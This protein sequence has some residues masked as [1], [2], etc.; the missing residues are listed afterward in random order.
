MLTA[1]DSSAHDQGTR[2]AGALDGLRVIDAATLAA[3]P[4]VA[5]TMAEFG[6]EVIKVEQPG[7]GDPLR[8][9]GT[10][11]NG[12]ALMWKSVGRN[13]KTVTLDLRQREG[14][15]LLRGLVAV[16]DV[17]IVNTRPG[18]LRRWGLTY[19]DLCPANEGLVML[20]VTGFGAGG[21]DS[22]RPGFGTLGEAMSGFAHLTGQKDGPPTLPPFPLADGVA[23]LT[24]T[25]AVMMVLYHRALNGGRGQ[26]IDVNLIEPL[27]R[28]L[29]HAVLTYDQL[30]TVL[31]R[32]GNRWEVSVPRNVYRTADDRWI[33]MSGS[34]PNIAVRVFRAIG[35]PDLIDHPDYRDAQRR[36]QNGVAIDELVAGWV[37]TKTLAEAIDVFERHEVAAAPVYDAQQLLGDRH[38]QARNAYVEVPDPD[39]GSM[40]VQAPV[41]R[42]SLT[43]GRVQRLGAA[44]GA[45]NRAVYQGL[46]GLTDAHL[47]EL[48]TAGVI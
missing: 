9:W 22:D 3:A 32:D 34:T 23:A 39:L 42:L 16:S 40:T 13:K 6:A 38:L 44:I 30:R 20:H 11:K 26:L 35:Q 18:T 46:L 27:A 4:M 41:A 37:A 1:A 17:L 21:P 12:V 43:P 14:Q 8:Q 19:E 48:E 29:E 5:T 31:A 7:C 15:E 33:A 47:E 10:Q 25:N 24:A 45:D 2:P 36:L 28:L